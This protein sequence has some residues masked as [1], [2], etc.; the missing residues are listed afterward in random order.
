MEQGL[1]NLSLDDKTKASEG[2]IL[3]KPPPPPPSPLSPINPVQKSPFS[4]Q[5]SNAEDV[6]SQSE[7]ELS[8]EESSTLKDSTQDIIDDDFGDFQAAG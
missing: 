2:S 8:P 7:A 4:S 3:L 1:N 5:P 6:N